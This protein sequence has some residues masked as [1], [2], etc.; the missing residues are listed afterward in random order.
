MSRHMLSNIVH[1]ENIEQHGIYWMEN[2]DASSD[3]I[4]VDADGVFTS[5]NTIL[6]DIS[7]LLSMNLGRQMSMMST[8][9]VDYIEL[10]LLNDD[11]ANDN[12]SGASFSGQCIYWSP[13]QHRI[14]AMQLARQVEK[15]D[16]SAQIDGDS[17]LLATESDY[18][19]MRF[20]WNDDDQIEHPT[21]EAFA[22]LSGTQWDLTELFDTY[23]QILGHTVKSNPLWERRTGGADK[24]GFTL[25]YWNN[26]NGGVDQTHQPQSTPWRFDRAVEVLGGLMA[27][28]FT[29]SSTDSPINVIDDDYKVM[30]TIG[31]SGWSDF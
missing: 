5:Q 16:E 15:M 6:V 10:Q 27:F 17:F 29:H 31:V 13:T 19:G 11:D 14:D 21:S 7:K 26:T 25:N 4:D 28:N 9:K 20:N 3:V 22:L 30:V 2:D 8:Y 24:I 12:D 18:L 1:G 23:G